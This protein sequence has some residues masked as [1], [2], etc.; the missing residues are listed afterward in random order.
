MCRPLLFTVQHGGA[1]NCWFNVPRTR[2]QLVWW[3]GF[4]NSVGQTVIPN[5]CSLL[6]YE[7]SYPKQWWARPGFWGRD[8]DRDWDFHFRSLGIKTKTGT[9]IFGLIESRPR[10]RLSFWVSLINTKTETFVKFTLRL[11]LLFH[12]EKHHVYLRAQKSKCWYAKEQEYQRKKI[13]VDQDFVGYTQ[14]VLEH[15]KW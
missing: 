12:S 7:S 8:R 1:L 3:F 9:F 2:C 10:P 6:S 14:K 4:Q 11:R 15:I 5:I 13:K